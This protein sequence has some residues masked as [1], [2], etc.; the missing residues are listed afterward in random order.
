MVIMDMDP[1]IDDAIALI[2]ASRILNIEGITTVC[3]NVSVKEASENALKI[4]EAL[5]L[6][7]P[8]YIG[9]SK[10]LKR[11]PIFAKDI[12]GEDGLGNINLPPPKRKPIPISMLNL[13]N[14]IIIATAPLTNLINT[15]SKLYIMGGIYNYNQEG[16]I[17]KYAEFN[18]YVD[19]EAA[20]IVLKNNKDI[21]ACGLDV[22]TNPLCAIN[23]EKLDI[24][25][26]INSIYAK[27]VYKLLRYPVSRFK[28]F[29]IHDVFAL[30]SYTNPEIF[31]YKRLKVSIDQ[32]IRGRC[33]LEE[34]VNGN[35]NACISVDHEA[36]NKLFIE[37]IK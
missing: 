6:D 15:N 21:T 9:A 14:N 16:N 31:E 3:G 17:T 36:F 1:G 5:N 25:Y 30:F 7:I 29:N 37:L 22:T 19:P 8:V 20:D 34:S 4:L 18:F 23:S 13:D 32:D 26:N 28:T 12:H 24:I 10:P 2:I 11:E 35:V 33:I 27:L